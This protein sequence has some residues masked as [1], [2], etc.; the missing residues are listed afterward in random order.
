MM[1][2]TAIKI[3]MEDEKLLKRM[4][5]KRRRVL[6]KAGAYTLT[7]MRRSMRYRKGPSNPS[8]PPSAHKQ[9][10]ALLRKASE[11]TVDDRK[12]TVV[13]G[14]IGFRRKSQPSGNPVPQLLN[15]GGSVNSFLKGKMVAAEIEPRPFVQPAF[16]DGGARYR[17]LLEKEQL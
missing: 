6:F 1:I 16:T 7:S 5:D 17:Q 10:G 3:V 4:R 9:N 8:F 14:P 11:F 12:G 13:I 15:E 2:K